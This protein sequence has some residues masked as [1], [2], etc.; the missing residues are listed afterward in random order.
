MY[1][2]TDASTEEIGAWIEKDRNLISIICASKKLNATQQ[3]WLATKRKLYTLV[4]RL[5]KFRHY[6]L[7]DIL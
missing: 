2:T 1:L 3:Q 6:L 4:W 5:K 7:G